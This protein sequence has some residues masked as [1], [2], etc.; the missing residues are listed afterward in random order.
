[1]EQSKP[2]SPST[3]LAKETFDKTLT[4]LPSRL[5]AKMRP[6]PEET[7]YYYSM[8]GGLPEVMPLA[9]AERIVVGQ[10]QNGQQ[11]I[12]HQDNMLKPTKDENGLPVEK[13]KQRGKATHDAQGK[14]NPADVASVIS[15]LSKIPKARLMLLLGIK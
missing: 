10:L 8:L 7:R 9:V 13:V 15:K 4:L 1:M 14:A 11:I 3:P 12:V 5:R 2:S 6:W